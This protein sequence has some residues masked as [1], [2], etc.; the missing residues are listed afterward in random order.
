VISHKTDQNQG[1]CYVTIAIVT[2]QKRLGPAINF[3]MW[4]WPAALK[5]LDTPALIEYEFRISG[6]TQKPEDFET[7][8]EKLTTYS[9]ST[10]CFKA[11][12]AGLWPVWPF[13]VVHGQK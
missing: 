5:R 1:I 4:K 2:S 13:I 10:E 8:Q 12:V 7:I 6:H 3:L 9:I 11:V